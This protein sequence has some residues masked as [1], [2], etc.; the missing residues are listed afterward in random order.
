M[1]AS[2]KKLDGRDE[3]KWTICIASNPR[4]EKELARLLERLLPQVDKYDGQIEILLFWNNFEYTLGYLRQRLLENARGEYI[5]HI[6]DDDMV[7]EDY[8]DTIFPLL[9]GVDYIGFKVDF[10]DNGNK[11]LPVYH[12][13]KYK[14]W[15]QDSDG[16][17]RG[18][19]HLN[20][21]RTELARQAEF[22]IE[23]LTGED[24]KWSNQIKAETEHFIDREM[25]T[26]NH[27]G[28]ESVAY[29]IEPKD[30]PMRPRFKSENIRLHPE[31]TLDA[32]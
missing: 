8:C 16:Y 22:P 9:D 18:V 6:D 17:Y 30:T 7:P 26:Y 23:R 2:G 10:I 29:K 27:V 32:R 12:S 19:T 4:R 13:L 20:P 31:S 25:Y 1:G 11:M 24:E 3:M 5:C 15:Y 21:L 28:D 14:H